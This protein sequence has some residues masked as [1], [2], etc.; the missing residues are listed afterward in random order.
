M[1]PLK[2]CK[3]RQNVAGAARSYGANVLNE[4]EYDSL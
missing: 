1:K 3:C 2:L 4:K